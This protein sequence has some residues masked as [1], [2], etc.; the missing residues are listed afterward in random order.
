MILRL[1]KFSALAVLAPTAFPVA[2]WARR[3]FDPQICLDPS[4][5]QQLLGVAAVPPSADAYALVTQAFQLRLAAGKTTVLLQAPLD[6]SGRQFIRSACRKYH[7]QLLVLS[8]ELPEDE[9]AALAPAY[10]R[11]LWAREQD[12]LEQ[13]LQFLDKEGIQQHFRIR[14]SAE[15][16]ALQVEWQP[17]PCDRSELAGPF[18]LIGS[19]HGCHA[20]LLALLAKLGY[21]RAHDPDG[22]LPLHPQ[23]RLPVFLGDMADRGPGSAQALALVKAMTTAGKA[24]TVLGNQ[25]RALLEFLRAEPDG[26]PGELALWWSQ[27]SPAEKSATLAWI[28]ALPSHLVLDGGR[29]VAVHGGIQAE[30]IGRHTQPITAFCTFG[31]TPSEHNAVQK[32]P[33]ASWVEDIPAGTTV[34]FAHQPLVD[35]VDAGRYVAV[36]TAC[37]YGGQLSAFRYPEREFVQVPAETAHETAT[38]PALAAPQAPLHAAAERWL[39]P[40]EH[41]NG[42]FL[43]QTTSGF[44]FTTTEAQYNVVTEF[45][46]AEAVSPRWLIYLPPSMSPPQPAAQAGYLEHPVEAFSYYE[47]KG[48]THVMVQEKLDGRRAVVVLCRD[49]AAAAAR[50]GAEDGRLGVVYSRR[51]RPIFADPAEERELLGQLHAAATAAGLWEALRTDWICCEG[52]LCG[53]K[54]QPARRAEEERIAAG[55]VAT[56]PRSLELLAHSTASGP[57]FEALKARM[58]ERSAGAQALAR[59]CARPEAADG[60]WFFVPYHLLAAQSGVFFDRPHAWHLEQLAAFTQANAP[61][62]RAL[63]AEL[64]DLQD[65]DQRRKLINWWQELSDQGAPGIV[66]KPVTLELFINQEYLQPAMKV[67][68]REAL[69]KVYGPFYTDPEL[70]AHHRNRSLKERREL[71]VRHFALGKEGLERFV[72]GRPHYEVFQTVFTH[73][74]ISTMDGNPLL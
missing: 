18:D 45:L 28:A 66:V 5:C 67:R 19:L 35:A 37:L 68:G 26:D 9:L 51:G 47:K 74:A 10:D 24:L 2:E 42:R 6:Q 22:L 30:M 11:A 8:I 73:L 56:W 1:P 65:H 59:I 40:D 3:H 33:L 38:W 61:R 70:L 17:L 58:G 13:N 49:Q 25:D 34:V 31:S 12:L 36:D 27:A 39:L 72:A 4:D 69:R 21:D 46:E 32:E 15:L 43:V 41:F 29:L 64:L 52:Q 60:D 20:E 55:V 44:T 23:G 57:E 71:S 62:V 54:F 53:G 7:T 48:Q 16:A 63:R 14:S 50:F